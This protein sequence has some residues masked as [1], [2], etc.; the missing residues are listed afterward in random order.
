LEVTAVVELGDAVEVEAV[1]VAA[2]THGVAMSTV[3][4]TM[5][6]IAA[7]CTVFVFIL[8]SMATSALGIYWISEMTPKSLLIQPKECPRSVPN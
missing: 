2:K 3:A 7:S 5:P 1:D 4:A 6:A 8:S